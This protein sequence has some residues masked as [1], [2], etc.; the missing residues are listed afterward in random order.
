M[1]P[2]ASCRYEVERWPLWRLDR[3]LTYLTKHLAHVRR[4]A[5]QAEIAYWRTNAAH[6]ASA[7]PRRVADSQTRL[8]AGGDMM[9]IRGG[10]ADVLSPALRELVGGADLSL[11]NL[12]TPVEP[13]RPVPRYTYET[14]RYNAPP[15]YLDAWAG[16]PGRHVLSLCNNHALDQ[17][18]A[19][20][21]AT[22]RGVTARGMIAIGGAD[23][24]REAVQP[25]EA[26]GLRFVV[27]GLTF[28]INGLG[29]G[30]AG[31]AGVPIAAF[32]DARAQTDWALVERLLARARSM[33]PD[34][35]IALPHWGYEYEYWP[36]AAMRADAHR[37]IAMGA[38]LILG[39]SPHVLQ[40]VELVSINGHDPSAPAQITRDGGA[41]RHG[42]IAYSLGDLASIL[43]TR[44][45]QAAGML[46][47]ELDAR[48]IRAVRATGTICRR[49]LGCGVLEARAWTME[50]ARGLLSAAAWRGYQG[51][52]ER[53]FGP[54]VERG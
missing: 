39:S 49:G 24:E 27:L 29:R 22:R 43:P 19:G 20:L 26:G 48:T 10:W 12:E 35:I 6:L 1:N 14:P 54:L 34:W 21:R 32:G 31:P 30:L 5:T 25:V 44:A 8:V 9:W 18:L 23:D 11:A 52:I 17:G 33:A 47:L 3:D 41:A 38:D 2:L 51:H 16:L 45:C 37:L 53:A 28:G 15:A 4:P 40:P 7:L 13:R 50:E 36:D 42:L 46:S